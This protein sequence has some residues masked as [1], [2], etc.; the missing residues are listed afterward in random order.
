M[1]RFYAAEILLA[2][3]YIH[4]H[5]IIYR[6]LK[7]SRILLD[8][9]GHIKVADFGLS[10]SLVAN[11]ERTVS[12]LANQIMAPEVSNKNGSKMYCNVC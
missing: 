1:V 9:E 4:L 8:A 3:E 10:K 5:N 7:P 2:L 12:V 6:D 11:Q